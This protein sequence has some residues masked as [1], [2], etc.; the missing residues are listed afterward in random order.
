LTVFLVAINDR[1][2]L[3]FIHGKVMN[4]GIPRVSIGVPVYNGERFIKE[5]LDSLLAQSFADFELLISDNGSTDGTAEICRAYT[6]IDNRV[7]YFRSEEN[8]GVNQNFNRVFAL[9]SGEYF[10]WA[11]ADDVC[12]PE[13]LV[14]CIDAL[15]RDNTAVL[16]HPRTRFID[17]EGS[18]VNM[19]D[20]GWDL[21]FE[22]AHDRLRYVILA[23]HW[24]NAHYG[25]IRSDALSKTR[26]MP[27]YPG[28]DYRLLGE[29]SLIGKFVQI[30]EY[31]FFRRIHPGASSQNLLNAAWTT[32]F[33]RGESKNLCLPFWSLIIDH[34]TTVVNSKLVVPN[35]VSLLGCLMRRMWWGHSRLFHE[36]TMSFSFCW[37]RYSAGRHH[38]R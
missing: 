2:P 9:S 16:A 27:S 1:S 7:S 30:P 12:A 15:D 3:K 18:P 23:D 25:L 37:R 22:S 4:R 10:K 24:V 31:L 17:E 35:K 28:G 38:A 32:E 6:A 21:P 14:H 5:A 26:L 34:C 13:H 29:L 8:V 20:P 36:L 11:S 19:V 33:H